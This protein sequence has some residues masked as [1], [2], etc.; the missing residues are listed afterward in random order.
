M[1]ESLAPFTVSWPPSRE[2]PCASSGSTIRLA[3]WP[4][5]SCP[6]QGIGITS[7]SAGPRCATT[8]ILMPAR[9]AYVVY[10]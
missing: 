3:G 10:L 2:T 7:T 5:S 4:I 8:A 6:G 9:R 1:A